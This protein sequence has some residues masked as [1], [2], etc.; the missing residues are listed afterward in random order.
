MVSQKALRYILVFF[1]S[2]KEKDKEMRVREL[3][4]PIHRGK[5]VFLKF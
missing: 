4:Y 3:I 2:R 1:F 5:T